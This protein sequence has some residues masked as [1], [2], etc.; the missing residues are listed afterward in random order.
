MIVVSI[1]IAIIISLLAATHL[2]S[3]QSLPENDQGLVFWAFTSI[4]VLALIFLGLNL[5]KRGV[6]TP[7]AG[8]TPKSKVPKWLKWCLWIGG[9]AIAFFLLLLAFREGWIGKGIQSVTDFTKKT[10]VYTINFKTLGDTL[11]PVDN[12]LQG[13]FVVSILDREFSFNC[14]NGAY[15][16]GHTTETACKDCQ[17][18]TSKRNGNIVL[19]V[20]KGNQMVRNNEPIVLYKGEPVTAVFTFSNEWEQEINNKLL[21]NIAEKD[22]MTLKIALTPVQ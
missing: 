9:I 7:T 15:G 19:R 4:G 6:A 16:N 14:T 22:G 11:I 17:S 18:I 12:N 8:A 5:K 3:T 2:T 1:L 20:R 10:T 13:K 21:C